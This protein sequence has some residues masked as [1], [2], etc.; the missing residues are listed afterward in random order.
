MEQKIINF[1]ENIIKNE[2]YKKEFENIEN[3]KDLFGLFQK[4][5]PEYV[6]TTEEEFYKSL[7]KIINFAE[8]NNDKDL[9]NISGGSANKRF[10][11]VILSSA[12]LLPT[13][14]IGDTNKTS[15]TNITNEI[16]EE[17][18]VA[19][20]IKDD[21]RSKILEY[22][23][24]YGVQAACALFGTAV[25]FKILRS[26]FSDSEK[27]ESAPTGNSL[28][29]VPQSKSVTAEAIARTEP[30]LE[31]LT[32]SNHAPTIPVTQTKTNKIATKLQDQALEPKPKWVGPYDVGQLDKTY[33]DNLMKRLPDGLNK[34]TSKD[35]YKITKD[36]SKGGETID[37]TEAWGGGFKKV[38]KSNIL[39]RIRVVKGNLV[40][41]R[42]EWYVDCIVNAANS[43]MRSGGGVDGAVHSMAGPKLLE[44]EEKNNLNCTNFVA[45]PTPAFNLASKGIKNIIHVAAP[46]GLINKNNTN[47]IKAMWKCYANA[48]MCAKELGR[49]NVAI[50]A[51]GVGIFK[52]HLAISTMIAYEAVAFMLTREGYENMNV[53]F[54]CF[55]G[56]SGDA[57]AQCA[58]YNLIDK[59]IRTRKTRECWF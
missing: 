52:D 41:P 43:N 11:S 6:N 16:L 56:N 54:V 25:V 33:F 51:L 36:D 19:E 30:D 8:I 58:I 29:T 17:Q 24:E 21:S 48:I 20:T 34:V 37:L 50:P 45:V 44:F 38:Y 7:D 23:C 26:I 5:N 39:D 10:S 12:L 49:A 22:I 13:A 53:T 3:T 46:R 18:V 55:N 14:V 31:T 28:S 57:H 4:Y 35:S 27:S 9:E 15:A 47:E 32:H 2:N 1:F 59:Q 40:D 42:P